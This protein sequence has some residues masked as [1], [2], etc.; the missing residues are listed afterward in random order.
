V[1]TPNLS[2]GGVRVGRELTARDDLRAAADELAQDGARVV[3][4]KGG[5]AGG[6]QAVDLVLADGEENE[7]VADRID[8]ANTHGT[9]CS[10]A[11]ATAAGLATGLS[12]LDALD[13]AK[14]YV[15]AGIA[16]A[17]G[18][19]LGHGTGPIDHDA[20]RRQGRTPL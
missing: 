13:Q 4:I 7:L 5:H 9:G 10:F 19:R 15:T 3:V 1:A 18:W 16:G 14:R 2:A 6:P 20:F 12:P 8:T 11:S 17:A